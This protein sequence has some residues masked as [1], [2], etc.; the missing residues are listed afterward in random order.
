MD[1]SP[2]YARLT[3]LVLLGGMLVG[4][5]GCGGGGKGARPNPDAVEAPALPEGIAEGTDRA[6][7]SLVN[8]FA[9]ALAQGETMTQMGMVH[10]A[11][12]RKW[13]GYG[14]YKNCGMPVLKKLPHPGPDAVAAYAAQQGWGSRADAF[15][16]ARAWAIL[17][18]PC[19]KETEWTRSAV[20]I[21]PDAGGWR[22]IRFETEG[23]WYTGP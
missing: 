6:Q 14:P 3:G 7:R 8:A 4:V 9:V 10:P 5:V 21:L 1:K 16:G 22:V 12:L 23:T 15:A 11:L 17:D 19:G 13:S 20:W 2:V 18:R